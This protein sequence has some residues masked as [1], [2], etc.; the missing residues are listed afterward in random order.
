MGGKYLMKKKKNCW[1][2]MNKYKLNTKK[3]ENKAEIPSV[4][5][6]LA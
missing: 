3:P 4:Q 6:L 1:K 2:N 5:K